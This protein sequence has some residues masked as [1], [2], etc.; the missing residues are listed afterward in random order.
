MKK[1]KNPKV[2]KFSGN[3]KNFNTGFKN[4]E[5]KPKNRADN[6]NILVLEYSKPGKKKVMIKN[7]AAPRRNVLNNFFTFLD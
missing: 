7:E 6:T 1:L 4:R 3:E 5:I 2:I